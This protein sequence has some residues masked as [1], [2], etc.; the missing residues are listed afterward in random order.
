MTYHDLAVKCRAISTA[1]EMLSQ[2]RG[3]TALED[4]LK[5]EILAD[6]KALATAYP[7]ANA[8]PALLE[9]LELMKATYPYSPP[10]FGW[11]EQVEAHKK[12]RAAIALARGEAQ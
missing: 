10:C 6:W 1:I 9:A 2:V 3:E 5:G 4:R 12:A 7:L 11:Q 8:A